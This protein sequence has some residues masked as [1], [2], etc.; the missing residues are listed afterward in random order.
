MKEFSWHAMD[1]EEVLKELGT[2]SKKGLV[3]DEAD[4]RLKEYGFNELRK[5]KK[6]SPFTIFLNQFNNILVIILIIAIILSALIGEYID[7]GIIGIIVIFVAILGFVNEFRAEKAL[8]ALKKMLSPSI[9]ALRN[10]KEEEVLSKELVPGDILILEAGDKIPADARI[11]ESHS[12]K[13]DESPLTGESFPVNKDK[14][15]LPENVQV[16]YRNNI[17]FTGTTVAYGRGSAVVTSTG[18]NTEFGEIAQEMTTVKT[19]K[20]PLEKRTQE[21]GRWLSVISVS[22]CVLVVAISM[23]REF[24]SGKIEMDFVI[25]ITM[26]GIALAVAA[27]P[28]ALAAIVTGSLAIGM[29]QMAKRNALVRKMPA[30]ETLGSVTVICSDKTGTLTKG[31]MTIRKIFTQNNIL[32]VSGTG[33]E[34]SGQFN[35]LDKIDNNSFQL[36]LKSGILCND[37]ELY[38]KDKKWSIKG[39]STEGA[40]LVVAAKN[41]VNVNEVKTKNQRIHEFP[42]SSE[43]KRM[44]TIHQMENGK[45]LAF[46]KGA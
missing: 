7:A 9:T 19:E 16:N 43:R 5:A 11:I 33:Y 27:V 6:I 10:G 22:I 23:I 34:P 12:L 15:K 45:K 38:E 2:D 32:E 26:F 20:T 28:E 25:K 14:N 39:D 46:I 41:N 44:T 24:S 3:K 37:S 31:E 17:L 21:I 29:H 1:V 40:L 4:K 42:F 18:M 36:L 35:G 30:V 8:D 13:C